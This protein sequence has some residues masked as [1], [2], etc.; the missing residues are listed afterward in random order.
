MLSITQSGSGDFNREKNASRILEVLRLLLSREIQEKEKQLEKLFRTYNRRQIIQDTERDLAIL[1]NR[2]ISLIRCKQALVAFLLFRAAN[3]TLDQI[4]TWSGEGDDVPKIPK[5]SSSAVS[6]RDL[7]FA[8]PADYICPISS[9]LMENPISTIDGFTYERRN[10]ER[11]LQSHETSPC[12][13]FILESMELTPNHRVKQSVDLWREGKDIHLGNYGPSDDLIRVHFLSPLDTFVNRVLSNITL[14]DLYH[15]ALRAT[16]G[17]YRTF[18]L[19]HHNTILLPSSELA[20]DYL[21]QR[22]T[23][24]VTPFEQGNVNDLSNSG[25]EDLYLI[26]VY[27]K[28]YKKMEFSYWESKANSKTLASIVFRYYRHY[29]NVHRRLDTTVLSR[30]RTDIWHKGDEEYRGTTHDHWESLLE[31]LNSTK[32]RGQLIDEPIYKQERNESHNSNQSLVLKVLLR[33]QWKKRVPRLLSRLDV[34]KQMFG[35]FIDRI[36]AYGYQTHMGLVTFRSEPSLTQEI[37]HAIENFRHELNNCKASGDTSLWDALSLARDTLIHYAAKYPEA[38]LRIICLSDGEDT[39]SIQPVHNVAAA[40]VQDRIIVD[41]FCLGAD[42]MKPLYG[43]SHITGGYKFQPD[44]LEHAMAICELEPVLSVLERPDI[45]PPEIPPHYNPLIRLHSAVRHARID[46]VDRDIFPLRK[47]HSL[48][49]KSYIE[50]GNFRHTGT[51]SRF[52]IAGRRDTNMRLSR[53]HNEIR[54]SAAKMHPHYD[55]YVCESNMAMWKVVMQGP[56]GSAYA[57]GTFLLYLEMGDDYPMFPPK[58]RFITP[59]YHPNINRH[60]RICHSIFDRNWTADTT[61]KDIIDTI[62]SLL[63]VPEFSDP[64]NTVVTLKFHWDEVQ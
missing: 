6:I 20:R 60:G 37:T 44:E 28:S 36:L 3:T 21:P 8:I 30:I 46:I 45:T 17:R 64:I 39:R 11:W 48:L 43:I 40:L 61:S 15:Q 34:L 12:T 13:N 24:T 4:M 35:A 53:I 7:D 25:H 52:D 58:G 55:I 9:D 33:R 1:Q 54:N 5:K 50:L 41:S 32:E 22:S 59:V 23:I 14:Q 62:Y 10:I 38:K 29:A 31:L 16:K 18:L 49:S 27:N 56:P 19:Q 51:A 47:E 57:S 2:M 63:L 42:E 26:K